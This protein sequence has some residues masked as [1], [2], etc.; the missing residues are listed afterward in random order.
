LLAFKPA[1]DKGWNWVR[2]PKYQGKVNLSTC[3]GDAGTHG[4]P[5]TPPD[6]A[7]SLTFKVKRALILKI[8]NFLSTQKFRETFMSV[9]CTEVAVT[10]AKQ[11]QVIYVPAKQLKNLRWKQR[12]SN[13]VSFAWFP[14]FLLGF[15]LLSGFIMTYLGVNPINPDNWKDF[16]ANIAMIIALIIQLAIGVHLIFLSEIMEET[17]ARKHGWDG[18]PNYRIEAAPS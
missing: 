9:P 14:G 16:V 13:I 8:P 10:P 4:K 2:I 18:K 3:A 12:L 7:K 6:Q 17:L 5:V 1:C 15:L 11:I